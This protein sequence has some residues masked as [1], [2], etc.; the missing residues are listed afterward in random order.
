MRVSK[1]V[2]AD[3]LPDVVKLPVAVVKLTVRAV[4]F[5]IDKKPSYVLIVEVA[6][7]VKMLR[8]ENKHES[9]QEGF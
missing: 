1:F 2:K 7:I 6:E 8:H 3:K 5:V 4:R 9:P